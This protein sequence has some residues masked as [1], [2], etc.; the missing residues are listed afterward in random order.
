MFLYPFENYPKSQYV[1]SHVSAV[2]VRALARG[3]RDASLSYTRLTY[4]ERNVVFY[5]SFIMINVTKYGIEI[6]S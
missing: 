4:S 2:H 6:I 5:I 3:K 1:I